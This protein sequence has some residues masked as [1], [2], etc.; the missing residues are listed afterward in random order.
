MPHDEKMSD[1]YRRYGSGA[2]YY[3]L[4]DD[5]R[6]FPRV[7]LRVPARVRT[8]D[9]RLWP[10]ELRDISPDGMHLRCDRVTA[11]HLHP[12]G[13]KIGNESGPELY[14][15]C[16]LPVRGSAAPIEARARVR[17]VAIVLHGGVAIGLRFADLEESTMNNLELFFGE[18][19]EP[20]PE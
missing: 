10:V 14:V 2:S 13:E 4:Y 7:D 1:T 11:S 12:D 15:L 9:G 20:G 18:Q 16:E 3:R 19:I 8:V 5:E 6:S 17:F